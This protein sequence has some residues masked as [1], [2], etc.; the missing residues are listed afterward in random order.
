[1][2]RSIELIEQKKEVVANP[3][4]EMWVNKEQ[5]IELTVFVQSKKYGVVNGWLSYEGEQ[6][7]L[8]GF[9]DT[10][11]TKIYYKVLA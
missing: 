1:M 10:F 6:I 3:I 8:L 4:N 11:A 7:S 9:T 5:A 2:I